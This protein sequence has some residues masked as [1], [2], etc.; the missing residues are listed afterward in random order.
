[1]Q[2]RNVMRSVVVGA[3]LACATLVVAVAPVSAATPVLQSATVAKHHHVLVDASGHTLYVLTSEAG[4]KV[5][6]VKTCLHVWLAVMLP[7][8]V[9]IFTHSAAVKGSLG[10]VKRG[11]FRQATF[12]GFPL[13]T[14]VGDTRA[15]QDRGVGF[16][17]AGGTWDLV[18]AA[19]K[20]A[21]ATPIKRV[22]S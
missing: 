10:F 14:Y 7:E 8:N 13:Y 5:K 1:V 22:A 4:G 2:P 3:T 11:R 18:N 21:S 17:T 12:N 15:H 9:S 19:A 20:T 6:C 16:T